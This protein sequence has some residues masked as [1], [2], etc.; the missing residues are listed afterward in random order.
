MDTILGLFRKNK[1]EQQEIV[2][3]IDGDAKKYINN[4]IPIRFIDTTT[5]KF[6]HRKDVFAI[7][8]DDITRVTEEDIEGRFTARGL[9]PWNAYVP[10]RQLV[11]NDIIQGIV[12][13]AM[14]S[15]RWDAGGEPT[16]RD[17]SRGKR[18]NVAGYAKL[19]QFCKTAKALGY[20]LAWSDTCCIDKGNTAEL[21]E[22][23][24]A[25]YKWYIHCHVCIVHLAGS[26]SIFEFEKESWFKRGWTLQ[27]LLAPKRVKFY[28]KDWEPFTGA[29]LTNDKEHDLFLETLSRITG[30]PQQ[31]IAADNSNGIR[32]R[33]I[34]EIMSWAANRQTTR[35]ED[36]AYSLIG[37]FDVPLSISYG[38]GE[39][40]FPRLVEAIIQKKHRWDV[41]AWSGQASSAH[42]AIP[43]SPAC[44]DPFDSQVTLSS[45]IGIVDF[46]MTNRGLSLKA[47]PPIPME[48]DSEAVQNGGSFAVT[49][50]PQATHS[51]AL[52]KFNNVTVT[53][54]QGRL[55]LIRGA[56]DLVVCILNYQH[57]REGIA[58]KL[59]IGTEY[60]C[61]L[62]HAESQEAGY[63]VW[64]KFSTQNLLRI[65]CME[66]PDEITQPNRS[67]T[68]NTFT[69]DP[70]EHVSDTNHDTFVLPLKTIYIRYSN[71]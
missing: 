17:I 36:V 49:L 64:S 43:Y 42:A 28:N 26:N 8:K 45:D 33:S 15:H 7:F 25:M 10:Q 23:V 41:F 44:Y 20:K 13:Y 65:R 40:A 55:G 12:R 46:A 21:S 63:S 11:V 61:F 19:S 66:K 5:M 18:S 51:P 2:G 22:A 38:E 59:K 70:G 54:G 34:W 14:F 32:N 58:G 24:Q 37:L 67:D 48:F 50:R 71:R 3:I 57:V 1:D 53:C 39:K 31:V 47:L 27:E 69:S 62:L 6:V 4:D 16:F 52:G 30:I 29:T 9:E 60:I 35:V 68:M 56:K